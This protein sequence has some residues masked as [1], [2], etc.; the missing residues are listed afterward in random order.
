MVAPLALEAVLLTF[1]V[2]EVAIKLKTPA[3]ILQKEISITHKRVTAIQQEVVDD[4]S[5]DTPSVHKREGNMSAFPLA[6][7][8]A[9]QQTVV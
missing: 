4:A 8:D 6:A 2:I 3:P 9:K 7:E 5:S 1:L